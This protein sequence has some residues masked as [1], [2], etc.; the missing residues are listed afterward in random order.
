MSILQEQNNQVEEDEQPQILEQQQFS[1]KDN[2]V[3][4]REMNAIIN[5]NFDKNLYQDEF[6]KKLD[7]E[8][9]ALSQNKFSSPI[10]QTK[11]KQPSEKSAYWE[12]SYAQVKNAYMNA[13]DLDEEAQN[14]KINLLDS[15]KRMREQYDQKVINFDE[16]PNQ[17]FSQSP[18]KEKKGIIFESMQQENNFL[19]D[20]IKKLEQKNQQ[21]KIQLKNSEKIQNEYIDKFLVQERKDL[22]KMISQYK[23]FLDKLLSDKQK[24]TE[25]N[26]KL[27]N[28]IY[29]LNEENQK[30]SEI[31]KKLS[32]EINYLIERYSKAFAKE[33]L[34]ADE[35]YDSE[36]IKM[37]KMDHSE[38]IESVKMQQ[39]SVRK[40][41]N[42]VNS[43]N[44]AK[45]S[46]LE[47]LNQILNSTNINKVEKSTKQQPVQLAQEPNEI[48]E[49]QDFKQD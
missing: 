38:N 5:Q 26:R 32:N 37:I 16:N 4:L 11:S 13:N 49:L 18:Q 48:G 34:E 43:A 30:Y 31:N 45:K 25:T 47:N 46:L 24:L 1:L 40:S 6:Q 9:K 35:H 41:S 8:D 12:T 23:Q 7:Y 36:Y 27:K 21:L 29:Y 33:E 14:L 2:L 42:S 28:E 15:I 17:S 10:K 19:K 3:S 44:Q 20:K 22:K 39:S